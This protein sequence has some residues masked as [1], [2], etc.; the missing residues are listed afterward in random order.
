V[1]ASIAVQWFAREAGSDTAAKLLEGDDVLTAPD[2]MPLEA[3]NAWWK[4][5]RRREMTAGDL[6]EA[7][8]NLMAVDMDWVPVG[9]LLARAATL[10]VQIAHPVYDCLYLVLATTRQA[11]LAT[12]DGRLRGAAVALGVPL[13]RS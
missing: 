2:V 12:G 5:V 13:W 6:D 11:R 1:D 3:A 4:K 10:A 9:R 8:V 7:L